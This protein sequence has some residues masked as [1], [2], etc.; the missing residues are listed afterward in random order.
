MQNESKHGQLP[1]SI[2]LRKH[3]AMVNAEL[4]ND[5]TQVHNDE[6]KPIT[7]ANDNKVLFACVAK[8]QLRY[9]DEN[10]SAQQIE[11][12]ARSILLPKYLKRKEEIE[13][14]LDKNLLT[15][16]EKEAALEQLKLI[17]DM[18][19]SQEAR[20]IIK[21]KINPE[22][23]FNIDEII[24][25]TGISSTNT[26]YLRKKIAALQFREAFRI[27]EYKVSEDLSSFEE[28]TVDLIPIPTIRTRKEKIAFELN[29]SAIPYFFALTKNFTQLSL[30]YIKE[31][32]SNYTIRLYEIAMMIRKIQKNKTYS[33]DELQRKFG[34]N[35][36]EYRFFKAKVLKVAIKEIEDKTDI[37]IKI[38]ERK[39]GRIV[40][41]IAFIITS[42]KGS[43]IFDNE[44]NDEILSTEDI[45]RFIT[46]RTYFK[47]LQSQNEIKDVNKYI[48]RLVKA[49]KEDTIPTIIEDTVEARKSFSDI[50]KIKKILI[51]GNEATKG[52]VWDDDFMVVRTEEMV[53]N[54]YG[55]VRLG[56][57]AS[58]CLKQIEQR[59]SGAGQAS[60]INNDP[61]LTEDA[62][63]AVGDF[64]SASNASLNDEEPIVI[65]LMD[66]NE[67]IWHEMAKKGFTYKSIDGKIDINEGNLEKYKDEMMNK[68]NN[69]PHKAKM[70]FLLNDIGLDR[71]FTEYLSSL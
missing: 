71:K 58:E 40:E 67:D 44:E 56:D 64:F 48:K 66:E 30:D 65:S 32:S 63:A 50:K 31:F 33:F 28:E 39:S 53:L 14:Q 21:K 6:I 20:R 13:Q 7:S 22:Y 52:L 19:I 46:L 47:R 45:A 68:I 41:K 24:K 12:E 62:L 35:Y 37:G 55:Y 5:H 16:E 54:N 27:K 18:G 38:D 59:L 69:G 23:E 10:Y 29:P 4:V 34:T 42:K 8:M 2:T 70:Y 1:F 25:L 51:L 36:S 49:I 15:F 9:K 26:H 60:S 61:I 11:E 43:H 57:T 3:N 17:Y